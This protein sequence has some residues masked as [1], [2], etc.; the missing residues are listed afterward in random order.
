[1]A[2][3]N[4]ARWIGLGVT[5]LIIAAGIITSFVWAQADIKAVNVKADSLK[6]DGCKPSK[7][8]REDILVIQTD[9]KYIIKGIDEINEK[10]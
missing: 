9:L 6:E 3:N 10:L 1:M 8:N 7:S 4:R 5:I 2:K